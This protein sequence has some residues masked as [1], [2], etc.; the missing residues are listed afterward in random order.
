MIGVIVQARMNSSRLPG[1]VMLT[2]NNRSILDYV[3]SQISFSKKI[4]KIIIATTKE[5]SDKP[6]VTYAKEHHI[7]F[8]QGS[9]KDVL[10]RYYQCAK[11]LNLSVIVRIT[12]DNPLVDPEIIDRVID[13]FEKN[14]YDYVSNEHPATF[15]QGYAV[16]V[17]SFNALE[18]AWKNA[19]KPSEREHV[20]PYFYNN[21]QKFSIFNVVNDQDLSNIRC[22]LDRENDFMFIKNVIIG[23]KKQPILLND[24][25]MVL[26]KNPE[27]SKINNFNIKNEGY[28]RSLEEDKLFKMS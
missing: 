4:N 26:E 2:I 21:P 11:K 7:R 27:L 12:S 18:D 22:T 24:V 13:E 20:T 28:L 5:I 14:N 17:F 15:P 19:T 25:L 6:I 3:I 9:E 10:D 16:E 23:I 8:F 1:K